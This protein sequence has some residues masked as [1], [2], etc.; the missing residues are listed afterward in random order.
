MYRWVCP[1]GRHLYST[2]TA[3]SV[4][5]FVIAIFI[6]IAVFFNLFAIN[7]FLQYKKIGKWKD[8]SVRRT[9]VYRSES[10]CEIRS[11]LAGIC[12]NVTTYVNE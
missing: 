11:C 7:M 10:R 1:L 4:P 2:I 5:D 6:T 12:W 3:G 9:N 8:Y